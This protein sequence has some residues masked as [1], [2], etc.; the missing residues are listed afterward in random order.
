MQPQALDGQLGRT[1]EI[2]LCRPCQSIWFD[3]H[4]NLQ[5]TP[6]A[7]LMMFRIIGESVSRPAPQDR[8]LARCPRCKAQLRR[9]HDL[10]RS[11]RFE[12]FRCPNEHG[13][14]STF[15]DFLREKDFIKPLTAH[16]IAELRKNVQFI[17]CSN[18]GAAVDLAK[19]SECDHCGTPLSMLDMQQAEKVI[20]QLREAEAV[21]TGGAMDPFLPLDLARARQQTE[22]LFV[23]LDH[24]QWDDA[25]LSLGLVGAGLSALMKMLKDD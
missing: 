7:T 4:E 3:Q 23:R 9:T 19:R 16:Q 18:C 14:L 8:D 10:Q 1:V 6:G 21:R 17:N 2:D 20:A 5:M 11:T 22:R 15:F 13:R 24:D 25:T 12:Y